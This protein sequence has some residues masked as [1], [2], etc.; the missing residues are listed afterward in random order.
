MNKLPNILNY[1]WKRICQKVVFLYDYIIFITDF[2]PAINVQF[3]PATYTATEGS[4]EEVFA[5][6]NVP[7][8]RDLTV[9]FETRDGT[10]TAPGRP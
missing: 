7:S 1:M 5:V 9:E 6:L 8:S 3:N 2:F 4:S 10:A